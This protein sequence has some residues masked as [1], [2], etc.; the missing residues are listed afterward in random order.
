MEHDWEQDLQYLPDPNEHARE[1]WE[2]LKDVMG[3]EDLDKSDVP[4]QS[5]SSK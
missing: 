2:W 4:V 3:D 5:S 1:C